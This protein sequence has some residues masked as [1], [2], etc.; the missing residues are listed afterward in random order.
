MTV[1][2]FDLSAPELALEITAGDDLLLTF[3]M[4][5]NDVPFSITGW[6][7]RSDV[8]KFQNNALIVALTIGSGI[9]VL[10]QVS[11]TLGRFNVLVPRTVTEGLDQCKKIVFDIETINTLSLKRTYL[12]VILTPKTP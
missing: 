9:T 3:T 10:P 1:G 5:E 12:K 8:R 7:I 11:P 6:V 2:T 4:T